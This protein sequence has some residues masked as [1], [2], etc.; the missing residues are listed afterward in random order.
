MEDS[1]NIVLSW[2]RN[3]LLSRSSVFMDRHPTACIQTNS[4]SSTGSRAQLL[5][6]TDDSSHRIRKAN[7]YNTPISFP[8]YSVFQR[9]YRFYRSHVPSIVWKRLML[10][11][12]LDQLIERSHVTVFRPAISTSTNR[13]VSTTTK[14]TQS[15]TSDRTVAHVRT[16]SRLALRSLRSHS[17]FALRVAS[18]ASQ[19][20]AKMSGECPL[21]EPERAKAEQKNQVWKAKR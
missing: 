8:L 9:F 14:I 7:A 5:S 10:K 15:T 2:R 19:P 11:P 4:G 1:Y 6:G 16:C 18:D 17:R 20:H 21:G 3:S 12:A 13:K